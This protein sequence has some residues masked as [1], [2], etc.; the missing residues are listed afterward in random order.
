VDPVTT[1]LQLGFYVLFAV[2]VWQFAR[3]RGRLELSVVAI[4]GSFAALFFLTF[5]NALQPSLAP[6]ARP[7][8]VWNHN[9]IMRAG[10]KGLARLLNARLI[11][12]ARE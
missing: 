10:G 6:I 2:S 9:L 12:L 1:A 4:F 3:R 5:L 11:S 7:L 8:F